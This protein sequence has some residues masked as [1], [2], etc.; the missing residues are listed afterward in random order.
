MTAKSWRDKVMEAVR[1]DEEILTPKQ[2]KILREK[3]F[4]A[5]TE[6]CPADVFDSA[7]RSTSAACCSNCSRCWDS[8]A[9]NAAEG[10]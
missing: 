9:T 4:Y 5:L 8:H 2:I 6:M 3:I 1:L 10:K 7:P